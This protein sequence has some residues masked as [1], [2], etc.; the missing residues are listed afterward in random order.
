MV[1]FSGNH[2]GSTEKYFED[3][4]RFEPTAAKLTMTDDAQVDGKMWNKKVKKRKKER[5]RERFEARMGVWD[6]DTEKGWVVVREEVREKV[7]KKGR[8]EIQI[9]AEREIERR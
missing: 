6:I 2:S 9:K 5:G 7:R 4:K 3:G 1:L 8:K